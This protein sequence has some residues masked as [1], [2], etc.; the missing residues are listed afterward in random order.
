MLRSKSF[1]NL[2]SILFF[3]IATGYSQNSNVSLKSVWQ[4]NKETDSIRF[5]ALEKYHE[6]NN[7]IE[8]DSTLL[9]LDYHYHLA[10]EKKSVQQ[11]FLASK[12]KGNIL[13]LKGNYEEAMAA[14]TEAESLANELNDKVL[15]ADIMGNMGNVFIYR[16]DYSLATQYFSNA[17]KMY[18]ESNDED[19][20]SHMFTS[21]GSV[22]LIIQNYDL[23]LE[24]YQK[25]LALRHKNGLEDR[26][27]AIIYINIGWTNFEKGLYREAQSYYEKG[28]K[29]LQ[30]KNE[31]FF[32]ANCYSTLAKIHLNLK[33]LDLAN[34]YAQMN[35][36]LNKEL[37]IESGILNAEIILAQL[38]A[39]T[40]TGKAVKMGESILAQLP[41]KTNKELR[42]DLYKLLYEC[43]KNQNKLD[44]SLTMHEQFTI[45]NDS[46]QQEKNNFAIAREAV[47]ND[48]EIKLYENKL[49]NEKAESKLKIIQVK[50]TFTII[51][52]SAL[53]ILFIILYFRAKSIKNL[54]RRD[55]L[56]EEINQLKRDVKQKV[57]VNPT[58][59]ELNRE[60]IERSIDRKLNET[61]WKVLTIIL[62]DPAI[63]NKEIAEQAFMSVDGI[64]SSLRRMYDYFGIQETK[65]KKMSLI[66]DAIKRSGSL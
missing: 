38:A 58:T 1:K 64:G 17:L 19:G 50:R 3:G 13:R 27:T 57:L 35:L 32:I 10:K 55:A 47:K 61:D 6:I 34:E 41:P 18:Q 63:S 20:E 12:R 43:Y 29:I 8:P 54:K 37:K 56:L 11:L 51:A 59:Y 49:E 48:F 4:N 66:T 30:I 44:A 22:Y 24:Y 60:N 45:Y 53:L 21:L 46:I 5:N 7:Q 40:N 23:A 39:K 28:L 33:E 52:V 42:R 14:Y 15:R 31:K 36:V 9:A 62:E 65:Y 16:Q 2:L 26:R 25:S